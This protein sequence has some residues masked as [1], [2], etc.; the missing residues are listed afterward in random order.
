MKKYALA[1]LLAVPLFGLASQDAFAG[2]YSESYC[3]GKSRPWSVERKY[4][5][6]KPAVVFDRDGRDSNTYMRL[7]PENYVFAKCYRNGWCQIE[8]RLYESAWV[9]AE[10]LEPADEPYRERSEY[11]PRPHAEFVEPFRRPR[12]PRRRFELDE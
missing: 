4:F 2:K 12:D 5:V 8:P 9:L 1:A 3:C 10:C 6:A 11:R 7:K